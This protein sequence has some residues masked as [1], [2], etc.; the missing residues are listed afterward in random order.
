[1]VFRPP[2]LLLIALGTG[3]CFRPAPG[4]AVNNAN[5]FANVI[6]SAASFNEML[7]KAI[8]QV[9]RIDQ[10]SGCCSELQSSDLP[11]LFLANRHLIHSRQ[12]QRIHECMHAGGVDGGPR[13]V[14]PRQGRADVLVPQ[15][16]RGA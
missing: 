9:C 2:D 3:A 12:W 4:V 13:H 16:Q 7:W 11:G 15:H 14:Q 5:F 10:L 1:M 8:G 6:N